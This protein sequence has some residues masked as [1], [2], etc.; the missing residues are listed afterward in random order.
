MKKATF[1]ALLGGILV[2]AA[3]IAQAAQPAVPKAAP[4]SSAD[5]FLSSNG[6]TFCDYFQ[7]NLTGVLVYGTHNLNTFCGVPNALISGN[8]NV[9]T[10]E[11][12]STTAT[13]NDSAATAAVRPA[14]APVC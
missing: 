14:G 11:S 1:R 3:S 13:T 10:P 4:V 7:V 9:T 2:C 5:I 6:V 8:A 12:P